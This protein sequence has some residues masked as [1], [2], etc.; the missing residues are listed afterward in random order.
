MKLFK[1]SIKL[2]ILIAYAM[3][4]IPLLLLGYSSFNTHQTFSKSMQQTIEQDKVLSLTAALQRDVMDLQR[5]VLIYKDTASSHSVNNSEQ[6]YSQISHTINALKDNPLLAIQSDKIIRMAE[7]LN[8]YKSSFDIVV[9]NRAEKEGLI[10][11]FIDSQSQKINASLLSADTQTSQEAERLQH[12]NAAQKNALSYFITSNHK[13]AQ[14]F[15]ESVNVLENKVSDNEA[16]YNHVIQYK[17]SFLKIVTVQRNYTYLINVVM[18]GSAREI[19]YFAD[20]LTQHAQEHTNIIRN[21]VTQDIKSQSTV[22]FILS[23]LSLLMAIMTPWYFLS[24]IIKPIHSITQVFKDL[25]ES[26]AVD[27]IPGLERNDEIGLLARAAD[28]FKSTNEQTYQLLQ[29]AKLS[30]AIQQKLNKELEEAKAHAEKSLSVKSD[31]LA[32][33]SHE[34]R[35]PLNSVIGYTVRLLKNAQTF[36]PRQV[37][38]LSAI[39]RNGKHLLAMINDILDLSKI[40]ANKLEVRFEP[41]DIYSLCE[42]VVDQMQSYSEEQGIALIYSPPENGEQM[43]TTD[44]IRLSQILMNLISN[45]LKYTEQG[46]VTLSIDAPAQAQSI[47][48]HIRDTGIGISEENLKRLFQRFEQFD[49][50]TRYKIGHGTGLGMAIVENVARLLHAKVHVSSELGKGSLFSVELP[51]QQPSEK[52]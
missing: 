42:D 11:S 20:E 47:T 36:T 19:L 41:V 50:E 13:Y 51:I 34:L 48:L 5:N 10:E 23:A 24:L 46:T 32:N 35:T 33:M 30:V 43:I 38:S 26:K 2:Q 12:I 45:G 4:A 25:S 17:K 39:E 7:H 6:L 52:V 9:K 18:A 44:P 22:F 8:D 21:T 15:K 37:S 1:S 49:S 3:L 27:K 29:Q 31:F 16:P 40:E 28:V 14:A